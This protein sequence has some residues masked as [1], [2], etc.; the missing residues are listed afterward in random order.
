VRLNVIEKWLAIS[1]VRMRV[2]ANRASANG[3]LLYLLWNFNYG[4]M[5]VA[6]AT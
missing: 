6:A 1:A 2:D 5:D 3:G 4:S